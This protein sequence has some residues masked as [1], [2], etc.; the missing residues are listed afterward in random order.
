M[1]V[2]GFDCR[3]D[4]L[5]RNSAM[6]L[7]LERLG[8]NA[9]KNGCAALLVFVGVRLLPDQEFISAA[10]VGHESRK[11]ALRAGGKEQC[12]LESKA[13]GGRG[14]QTIDGRIVAKHI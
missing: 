5:E 9:A 13:L 14:L 1:I 12:A 7:V 3:S 2:I 10:A 6:R 8:L 4:A 11:I